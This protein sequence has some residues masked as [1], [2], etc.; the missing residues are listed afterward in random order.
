MTTAT[1][2]PPTRAERLQERL[3][4]NARYRVILERSIRSIG[5]VSPL[6]KAKRFDLDAEREALKA[7]LR[8]L[9][10]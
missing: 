4:E 5:R 1:Y 8:R 9:K 3:E 7:S 10:S 2:Q 6:A